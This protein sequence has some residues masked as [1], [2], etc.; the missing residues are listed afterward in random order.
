MDAV[1]DPRAHILRLSEN[2]TTHRIAR[3]LNMENIEGH[4]K[5]V[6]NMKDQ[7]RKHYEALSEARA[8]LEQ[9]CSDEKK[10]SEMAESTS[11]KLVNVRTQMR[12]IWVNLRS[13]ESEV[14]KSDQASTPLM[15]G[16]GEI[17]QLE[18]CIKT[19][20]LKLDTKK[21]VRDR[22]SNEVSEILSRAKLHAAVLQRACFDR[23]A[24]QLE[25]H[26]AATAA[27]QEEGSQRSRLGEACDA[28]D[29]ARNA[30][31]EA[32][33]EL[34][35]AVERTRRRD[36][37]INAIRAKRDEAVSEYNKRREGLNKDF[38]GGP[39]SLVDDATAAAALAAAKRRTGIAL[40]RLK[41]IQ[42]EFDEV[43]ARE[44]SAAAE[45]NSFLGKAV[46]AEARAL[47]TKTKI[48]S[49]T[50][51]QAEI[52][53]LVLLGEAEIGRLVREGERLDWELSHTEMLHQDALER[54]AA[55]MVAMDDPQNKISP[56]CSTG[57]L[58]KCLEEPSAKPSLEAIPVTAGAALPPEEGPLCHLGERALTLTEL[59]L[60]MR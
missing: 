34:A 6:A 59:G 57:L 24:A 32:R 23:A 4:R 31:L 14:E 3:A 42:R 19:L 21:A 54:Q 29:A 28:L 47:S 20:N 60:V 30:A 46:E 55:L 7:A 58:A 10:W 26:V 16:S 13:A 12:N 9:H 39:L 5:E 49:L 43:K 18:E 37:Q 40:L 22:T 1:E 8:A 44:H 53:R 51:S 11:S 48:D 33:A 15:K 52:S 41:A 45:L 2:V 38:P 25:A 27:A 56:S 36:F 50:A 17:F 35:D